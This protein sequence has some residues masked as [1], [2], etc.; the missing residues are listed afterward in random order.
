MPGPDIYL[1]RPAVY[2]V[3]AYLKDPVVIVLEVV[4]HILHFIFIQGDGHAAD[5]VDAGIEGIHIH[6][7]VPVHLGPEVPLDDPVDHPHGPQVSAPLV[8]QGVAQGHLGPAAVGHTVRIHEVFNIYQAVPQER[9][10]GDLLCLL[11]DGDQDHGVRVFAVLPFPGILADEQHIDDLAGGAVVRGSGL[12]LSGL[13][14]FRL[15]CL[16][17]LLHQQACQVTGGQVIIPHLGPFDFIQF[18]K[19]KA[20]DD[21]PKRQYDRQDDQHCPDPALS[22][23]F[24]LGSQKASSSTHGFPPKS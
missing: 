16:G 12:W 13:G 18:G 11:I 21:Q 8:A 6:L 15:C 2:Q 10:H 19:G 3:V 5:G 20:A 23:L 24:R 22:F 17:G 1:C 4:V 9:S 7:D 14:G